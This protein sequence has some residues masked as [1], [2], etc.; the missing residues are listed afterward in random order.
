MNESKLGKNMTDRYDDAIFVRAKEI[1]DTKKRIPKA[2]KRLLEDE[3]R[4]LQQRTQIGYELGVSW[5]PGI[6]KHHNGKRLSEEV[7]GNTI[8]IYSEDL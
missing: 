8:I 6:V 5:L 3:L 2:H 1:A 7:K 4:C